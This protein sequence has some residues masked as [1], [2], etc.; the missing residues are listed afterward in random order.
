MNLTSV[1][2]L[3]KALQTPGEGVWFGVGSERQLGEEPFL[4]C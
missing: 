3:S 2:M 1:N 4:V